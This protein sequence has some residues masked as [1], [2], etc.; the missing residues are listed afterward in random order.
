MSHPFFQTDGFADKFENE[1]RRLLDLEIEQNAADRQR[2][3][4]KSKV[5]GSNVE[6]GS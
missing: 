2:R 5:S 6:N 3:K 4:R 1:L